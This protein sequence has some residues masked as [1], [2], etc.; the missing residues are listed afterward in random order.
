MGGWGG[1]ASLPPLEVK[2]EVKYTLGVPQ[3]LAVSGRG[4]RAG[5]SLSQQTLEMEP[6][7]LSPWTFVRP[8]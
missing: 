1:G 6:G 5:V 3:A 2:V 4:R 8:D 7:G